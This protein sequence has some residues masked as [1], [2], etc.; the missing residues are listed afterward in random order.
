MFV[1]LPADRSARADLEVRRVSQSKE[2]E[3]DEDHKQGRIAVTRE[4]G[5]IFGVEVRDRFR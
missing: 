5:C 4:V 1:D 3:T 2:V